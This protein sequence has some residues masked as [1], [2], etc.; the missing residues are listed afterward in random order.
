MK[1]LVLAATASVLALSGAASAGIGADLS[2]G[3][4]GVSG[5]VHYQITPFI[6][7][8]GGYNYF[9]Y[10][11]D[12]EEFDGI[13]YDADLDFSQAGGFIDIHPFMNGLT[14][15]GGALFGERILDLSATPTEDIEIGDQT[16]TAAEVGSLVGSANFGDQSYYA[17]VGWDTTTHGLMPIAFVLRAGVLITDS[18]AIT[19][20]NVGGSIDPLI[21]AEIDA[22]L[23]E[24]IDQLNN[25][26]EKFEFFPMI[27][28]GIG[29]GF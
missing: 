19:L 12:D 16:F 4:P 24:E 15:S 6:T 7:L 29:I 18:P 13:S 3:T 9:E 26:F 22:E 5:N 21:Q 11:L 1:R 28:F 14:I 23:L 20:N 17:G 10:E 27:S 8:R 25:D 2:V